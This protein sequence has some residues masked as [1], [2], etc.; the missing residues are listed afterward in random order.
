MNEKI[1]SLE[2]ELLEKKPWQLQG[3]VTAQKR[4]ENS[5]LEETLL[6]DHAVRLGASAAGLLLSLGSVSRRR[7]RI[8]LFPQLFIL[9]AFWYRRDEKLVQQKC[10]PSKWVHNC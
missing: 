6:F 9:K 3:E 5:L 1:A 8:V 10:V 2:K 7:Q 4:P